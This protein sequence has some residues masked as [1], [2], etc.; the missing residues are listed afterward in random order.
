MPS[1]LSPPMLL[2][3]EQTLLGVLMRTPRTTKQRDRG[4]LVLELGTVS[5]VLFEDQVHHRFLASGGV[6]GAPSR[7]TGD[8]RLDVSLPTSFV[9][10]ARQRNDAPA[11]SVCEIRAP[12]SASAPASRAGRPAAPGPSIVAASTLVSGARNRHRSVRTCRQRPCGDRGAGPQCGL[13]S[14]PATWFAPTRS[15]TCV[16]LVWI[17]LLRSADVDLSRTRLRSDRTSSSK[18]R[19][20]LLLL[21]GIRLRG[22]APSWR[23]LESDASTPDH[24]GSMH[25]Q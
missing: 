7:F 16:K 8:V 17:K 4:R 15:R 3:A 25:L 20:L 9:E 24:R 1:A 21:R 6:P 2:I 18:V 19:K 14:S 13:P 23:G 22:K 12:I 10:E 5:N 11:A